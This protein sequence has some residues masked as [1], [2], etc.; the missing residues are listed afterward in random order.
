MLTLCLGLSACQRETIASG[1]VLL[2]DDFSDNTQQWNTQ[3]A[4]DSETRLAQ[5]VF[6]IEVLG[7]Q[8]NVWSSPTKQTF[9]AVK[10]EVTASSPSGVLENGFGVICGLQDADHFFFFLI[11]SDGYYG[12]GQRKDGETTYL[13]DSSGD[14]SPSA[15]ILPAPQAN[16]LQATCNGTQLTFLVNGQNLADIKLTEGQV[17]Q[18]EIALLA[19]SLFE[20]G[21]TAQFDNLKITQP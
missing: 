10:I 7:S 18:G 15:H 12:V 13:H 8:L 17:P 11:S 1:T 20:G 4:P 5:G 2:Q 16:H 21:F 6:E 19:K 9:S 14:M 3:I